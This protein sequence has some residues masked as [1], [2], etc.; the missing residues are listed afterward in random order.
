[1]P[2]WHRRLTRCSTP[3]VSYGSVPSHGGPAYRPSTQACTYVARSSDPAAQISGNADIDREAIRQLLEIRTELTLD[4]Q[5]PSIEA[6]SDRLKSMWLPDEQ[7]VYIGL[8]GTSLEKR[9]SQ[10]NRPRLGAR[11][12]HAGGWP[13]KCLSDLSTT[14]V[15]YGEC[16]NFKDAEL[17]M[18]DAFMSAVAPDARASVLDPDLPLPFGNLE[19][20]N[21]AKRRRIKRHGIRGATAARSRDSSSR[22][23]RPR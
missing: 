13:L 19:F 1:M 11:S 8:A 23:R 3:P 10:F 15:H 22:R 4:G 16:T 9:V 12:P 6:L 18:L 17:K 7:A 14:W 5:Q 20:R 21:S 2:S